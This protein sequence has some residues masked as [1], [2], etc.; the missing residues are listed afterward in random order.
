[1]SHGAERSERRRWT[2]AV[3]GYVA[4]LGLVLQL[5][6]ALLPSFAADFAV[7][8]AGLG[9]VATAASSGYLLAV[10]LTGS[11]VGRLNARRGLLVALP[12]VSAC[13]LV[14]GA[15]P[16]FPALLAGFVLSG[17]GMG[18][19][20]AFDRPILSHLYPG[21]RARVFNLQDMAWAVG[22]TLGPVLAVLAVERFDW[23]AAFLAAA[24]LF[25]PVVA[26]VWGRDLPAGATAERDLALG[27]VGT[28][29]RR[30][31]MLWLAGAMLLLAF[32]ESGVF[33]WLPYY[34]SGL[35]G[36]R[37]GTL[38]LSAYLA[39]YVPGRLLFARLA[40]RV[41][42]LDL[43]LGAALVG[44]TMLGVAFVFAE[45]ALVFVAV[46]VV[47]FVVAGMFPTLLARAADA[48]PEYSA[49]INAVAL[50]ASSVGFMTFPAAMGLVAEA[51]SVGTAMRLLVPTMLGLAVLVA[52]VRA[53]VGASADAV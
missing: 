50:G 42:P 4:V 11:L 51:Y 24:V 46:V 30:P 14:V 13:L 2:V 52:A 8:E 28:L 48:M 32:V 25:L 7:S 20:N 33:T 12:A 43:V 17:V 18:A 3:F 6:G 49:P 9:L 27:E 53:R 47:G 26:L 31:T 37:A 23:R 5:R 21:D 39:A 41:A 1:M 34:A 16:T 44:A 35:L 36:R 40:G 38:S 29:L 15:A 22:A 19:L 45:G 10:L